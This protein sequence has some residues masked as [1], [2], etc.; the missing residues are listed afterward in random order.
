[1]IRITI[2]ITIVF[3]YFG[4]AQCQEVVSS[5]AMG[6]ES[7]RNKVL[8]YN[9]QI[10]QSQEMTA[11]YEAA[12]KKVR[13]GF[14]PMLSASAD[15]S[16]NFIN[17]SLNLGAASVPM[18]NY[19]YTVGAG[20]TQNVYS[21]SAVRNN[22]LASKIQ[23]EMAK[24]GEQLTIDNVAYMADV[25]YWTA[26]AQQEGYLSM[27]DYDSIVNSLYDVVKLRFEDGYVSKTDLL[28]VETRKM[29]GE[30]LL[31]SVKKSYL[32]SIQNL[33]ILMGVSVNSKATLTDPISKEI[34]IP[35]IMPLDSVLLTRPDYV[36]ADKKIALQERYTKATLSKFLPQFIV[37][38]DGN[39]GTPPLNVDGIGQFNVVAYG[40]L[41][42]PIF[43]WLERKHTKRE[44]EAITRSYIQEK[45]LLQDNIN[46]ELSNSITGLLES[47][48]M[49]K[50][51]EA[52]FKISTSNLDLNTLS[53]NEGKLPII[54]VLS[55]QLSWLNSY[56]NLIDANYN[57]KVSYAAYIKAV[58]GIK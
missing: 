39:Y 27:L 24:L 36:I 46:Q 54:D 55:S 45:S 14:Y 31:N 11:S 19:T 7:Y 58:G 18:K 12:V 34:P 5:N 17:K 1:M 9:Q 37:G 38:I 20:I 10:K 30:F 33:N 6:I 43:N 3:G 49:V 22:W 26:V 8:E 51:A 2:L 16:Y 44:N 47:F 40:Q 28:M 15:A 53:Y 52:S 48:E 50:I 29:E 56:R 23:A 41:K 4:F 25:T 35:T 21:G 57:Y 42:V 13:T 32:T